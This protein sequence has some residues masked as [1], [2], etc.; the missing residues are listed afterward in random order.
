MPYGWAYPLLRCTQDVSC[1]LGKCIVY[2]RPYW[3]GGLHLQARHGWDRSSL[4]AFAGAIL[5]CLPL[6]FCGFSSMLWD[7]VKCTTTNVR[8]VVPGKGLIPDHS[9]VRTRIHSNPGGAF[10]F[11]TPSTVARKFILSICESHSAPRIKFHQVFGWVGS[12]WVATHPS[13]W[14]GL[15]GWGTTDEP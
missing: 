9:V 4:V 13:L 15:L 3:G 7:L 5:Q 11:S 2:C 6:M 12:G 8:Y 10:Q 1:L 14:L